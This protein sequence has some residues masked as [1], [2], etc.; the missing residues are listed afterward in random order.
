MAASATFV[1]DYGAQAATA[2]LEAELDSVKNLSRTSFNAGDSVYFRIYSDISYTVEVSSGSVNQEETDTSEL[3]EDEL[4][5]F[6]KV[7]S[8]SVTK[9]I[10]PSGVISPVTWYGTNL[11]TL[12]RSAA[13]TISVDSVS[14]TPL[15]ICSASYLTE[16]DLWKL[17]PP[18]AM[19]DT[20]AILVYIQG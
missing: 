4:L 6:G 20:Y 5:S 9:Y 16:Y 3:I 13:K 10:K 8:V 14:D 12:S 1:I 7:K 18:G 15:G 2:V 17:T 11:G 19:P